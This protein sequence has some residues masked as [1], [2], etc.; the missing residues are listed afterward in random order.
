MK[1]TN[2]IGKPIIYGD[3]CL[4][5]CQNAFNSSVSYWLSKKDCWLSVYAFTP[6]DSK[7]LEFHLREECV[8]SYI[9]FFESMIERIQNKENKSDKEK[10]GELLDSIDF[11]NWKYDWMAEASKLILENLT[12]DG[13]PDA[14]RASEIPDEIQDIVVNAMTE[15]D[16]I[17]AKPSIYDKLRK[18]WILANWKQYDL[19]D[20]REEMVELLNILEKHGETIDALHDAGGCQDTDFCGIW[21]QNIEGDRDV[22]CRL[23]GYNLFFKTEEDFMFYVMETAK[24]FEESTEDFLKQAETDKSFLDYMKT[25][26]GYVVQLHY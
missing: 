20:S 2:E 13:L 6:M 10:A 7:D 3:Y 21:M 17:D 12:L 15:D 11:S 23:R 26:D 22:V 14:K 18:M 9:S 24:A 4:T 5:P 8:K 16:I 1:N 25:E 19:V